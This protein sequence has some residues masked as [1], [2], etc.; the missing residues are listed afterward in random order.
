MSPAQG[1]D[2]KPNL[3][4]AQDSD[5]EA[6]RARLEREVQE[7]RSQLARSNAMIEA[8]NAA[9]DAV[10]GNLRAAEKKSQTFEP[11]ADMRREA[12]EKQKREA[13]QA[14][15][16]VNEVRSELDK[17]KLE[18]QMKETNLYNLQGNTIE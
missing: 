12:M 13:S 15:R 1:D 18:V 7:M 5:G 9:K 11:L 16:E 8:A 3:L 2:R 14:A 6:Y 17:A 10:I 4:T